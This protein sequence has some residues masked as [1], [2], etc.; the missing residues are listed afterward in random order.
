MYTLVS[1][2][3]SNIGTID[4]YQEINLL[5]VKCLLCHFF[6]YCFYHF[7]KKFYFFF[8]NFE[9]FFDNVIITPYL[10]QARFLIKVKTQFFNMSIITLVIVCHHNDSIMSPHGDMCHYDGNSIMTI[11]S[12]SFFNFQEICF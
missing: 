2:I 1:W 12:F 6:K 10:S 9:K 7:L 5:S 3:S 4:N 8:Q 11:D